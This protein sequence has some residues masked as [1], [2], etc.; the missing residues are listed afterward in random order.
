MLSKKVEQAARMLHKACKEQ[1]SSGISCQGCG[2]FTQN[3]V[4]PGMYC[5]VGYPTVWDAYFPE[6]RK[7][8]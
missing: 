5:L 6:L 1:H 3:D 2:F 8:K 4:E 7:D